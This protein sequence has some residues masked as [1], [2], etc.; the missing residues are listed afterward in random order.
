[1]LDAFALNSHQAFAQ[2]TSVA[3]GAGPRFRTD[4]PNADTFG[5]KEGYP[6]CKGLEYVD[7]L[8][9][10]V[11]AFSHYDTLFPARTITAPK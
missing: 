7:Q 4:G 8:H 5:Q 1:M 6:R 10:R 9:C 3:Q 11:G 2:A